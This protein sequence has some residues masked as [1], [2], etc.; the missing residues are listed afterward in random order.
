LFLVRADDGIVVSGA[1]VYDKPE[2]TKEVFQKPQWKVFIQKG[3]KI[4]FRSD[5]F[6]FW[7]KTMFSMIL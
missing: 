5:S 4:F 7:V 6:F 2:T 1:C 3:G